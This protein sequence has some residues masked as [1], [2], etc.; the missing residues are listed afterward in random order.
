MREQLKVTEDMVQSFLITKELDFVVN[1][2][3]TYITNPNGDQIPVGYCPVR[4]DT[5]KPLSNGGLTEHFI[6]I[7]NRDAFRVIS[8]LSG[9]RDNVEIK[10]AGQWGGGAGVFMQVSLG[11]SFVGSHKDRIGNYLS[12][13]NAHDGSRCLNI[14]LTPY[15]YFCANQ[16]AK[17][18]KNA[19]DNQIISIRHNISAEQRIENLIHSVKI[20]DNVFHESIETFNK[21]AS[22]KINEEYVKETLNRCFPLPENAGKRGKTIWEN[23][24]EAVK[25]RFYDADG[26]R[27][28]V[29]TAWNLYNAVQGTFQHDSRRTENYNQSIL[30]GSIA[31]NSQTALDVVMEICSSEHIPSTIQSEI[32]EMTA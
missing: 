21:L 28:E 16:I 27:A 5:F 17:S 12:V 11:D 26:G 20:A 3:P 2:E 1:M 18:I 14:I 7:Q 23:K 31:K 15:R 9:I 32:E 13:V 30:M 19:K 22:L 24:V 29:F 10:N 25:N 4:M 6:P 8:E